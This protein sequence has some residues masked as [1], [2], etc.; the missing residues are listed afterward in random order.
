MFNLIVLVLN[1]SYNMDGF[2][3]IVLHEQFL[4][5]KVVVPL[6]SC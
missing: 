3:F 1:K 6:S 5:K 2:I 4:S